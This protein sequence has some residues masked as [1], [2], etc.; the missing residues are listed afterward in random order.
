MSVKG[1]NNHGTTTSSPSREVTQ[2]SAVGQC[3]SRKP[4]GVFQ[5]SLPHAEVS[6]YERHAHASTNAKC[7]AGKTLI[8]I[9]RRLENSLSSGIWKMR[10]N[11]LCHLWEAFRYHPRPRAKAIAVELRFWRTREE[12]EHRAKQNNNKSR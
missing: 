3:Q 12:D 8:K 5:T 10:S 4:I 1:E 6:R 11:T 7:T 9:K 2:H